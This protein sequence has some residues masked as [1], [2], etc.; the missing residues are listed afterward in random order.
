MNS[1]KTGVNSHNNTITNCQFQSIKKKIYKIKNNNNNNIFKKKKIVFNSIG[2]NNSSEKRK[3]NLNGMSNNK[4]KNYSVKSK[5]YSNLNC[6]TKCLY[7]R[8]KL[9]DSVKIG[10]II[11]KRNSVNN[12]NNLNIIAVKTINLKNKINKY[13]NL[14]LVKK[15]DQP[16]IMVSK[17]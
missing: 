10:N 5:L 9:N 2:N 4:G 8:K 16:E 7:Q 3:I 13:N 6:S 14:K 11:D 17:S 1:I 12:K 15:K